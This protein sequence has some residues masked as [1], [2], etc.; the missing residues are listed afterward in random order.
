MPAGAPTSIRSI[1]SFD[2]DARIILYEIVLP[3]A[4]NRPVQ[5]NILYENGDQQKPP[6]G[7]PTMMEFSD[8]NSIFFHDNINALPFKKYHVRIALQVAKGSQF[9]KGPSLRSEN[10][11]SKSH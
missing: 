3:V 6:K 7:S 5:L 9:E 4:L 1:L 8:T 2:G 11:I 10:M